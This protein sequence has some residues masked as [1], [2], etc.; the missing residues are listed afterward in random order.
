VFSTSELELAGSL[1]ES[2]GAV[3]SL[4]IMPPNIHSFRHKLEASREHSQV[5]VD[6]TV[7]K[8]QE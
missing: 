4:F 7:A 5:S 6:S 2:Y 3:N 1:K 8:V